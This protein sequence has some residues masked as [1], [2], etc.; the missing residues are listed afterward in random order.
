[1]SRSLQTPSVHEQ[2]KSLLRA[3]EAVALMPPGKH[4]E[5]KWDG[6]GWVR[7]CA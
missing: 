6:M 2:S 7:I 5:W 1:M 3:F 4:E